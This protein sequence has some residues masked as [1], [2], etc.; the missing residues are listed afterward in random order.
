MVFLFTVFLLFLYSHLIQGHLT[1]LEQERSHRTTMNSFSLMGGSRRPTFLTASSSHVCFLSNGLK[2]SKGTAGSA[3]MPV[4]PTVAILGT[5]DF[6]RCLTIRLL[7]CGVHVVVGS[8]QPKY[9]AQ[10]F[11]HVV[12]VTHH[13]DAV[14]KASIIFLAIHREHYSILWDLKHL[15]Q[16]R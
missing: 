15:L 6:S 1:L 13:D 12:D 10:A 4:L 7:R 2:N 9:A 3:V 11:P 5:G 16:G 8:R 14:K